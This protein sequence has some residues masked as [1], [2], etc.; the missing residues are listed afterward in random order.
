MKL[1]DKTFL[2]AITFTLSLVLGIVIGFEIRKH[3]EKPCLPERVYMDEQKVTCV[4]YKYEVQNVDCCEQAEV[5]GGVI[6]YLDDKCRNETEEMSICRNK[7][8][9]YETAVKWWKDAVT[10]NLE[11]K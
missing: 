3:Q 10:G 7:L 4:D 2:L 9:R 6:K 1:S 8:Q 5:Y 11:E